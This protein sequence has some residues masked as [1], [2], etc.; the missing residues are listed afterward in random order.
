VLCQHPLN[1]AGG[2]H[3]D[4]RAGR[5]VGHSGKG[6]LRSVGLCHGVI[7]LPGERSRRSAPAPLRRRGSTAPAAA[8]IVGRSAIEHA[9]TL[10]TSGNAGCGRNYRRCEARRSRCTVRHD[11]PARPSGRFARNSGFRPDM[12]KLAKSHGAK[13]REQNDELFGI[14]SSQFGTRRA[15]DPGDLL[16]RAGRHPHPVAQQPAERKPAISP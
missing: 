1:L 9:P 16:H 5:K 10:G 3:A 2:K 8:R 14:G 6:W 4:R 7:L 11:R 15:G 13:V 12:V